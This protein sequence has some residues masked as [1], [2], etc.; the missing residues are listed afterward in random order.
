MFEEKKE[1]F[2]CNVINSYVVKSLV[3]IATKLV[4]V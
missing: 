2:F 1:V 3:P 4:L